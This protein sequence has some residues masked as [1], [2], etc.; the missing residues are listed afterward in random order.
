MIN[1]FSKHKQHSHHYKG[2][3]VMPGIPFTNLIVGHTTFTFPIFEHTFYPKPL[4]LHKAQ[5]PKRCVFGCICQRD[6]RIRIES[7]RFGDDQM[8]A[9][10]IFRFP[11]PHIY[12]QPKYSHF[13][14]TTSCVPK[15][16][17]FPALRRY[18]FNNIS[19]LNAFLI[20]L[21]LFRLTAATADFLWFLDCSYTF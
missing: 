6:L 2:H 5:T 7:Q 15:F 11:I 16:N 18:R 8:P 9:F 19:N 14:R 4:P 12:L 13:K 17:G 3:M 1:S 10:I 21:I 20:G